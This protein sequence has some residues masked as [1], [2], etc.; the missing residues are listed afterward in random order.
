MS[1]KFYTEEN[2]DAVLYW[3]DISSHIK[4]VFGED[5][6]EKARICLGLG[7]K[8]DSEIEIMRLKNKLEYEVS[9]VERKLSDTWNFNFEYDQDIR[10]WFK[11]GRIL[12]F[13][14][15]DGFSIGTLLILDGD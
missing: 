5:I 10:I 1:I 2:G 13:S 7:Y 6:V 8:D 11:N 9:K 12:N 15:P 14:S 4:R 3:Y